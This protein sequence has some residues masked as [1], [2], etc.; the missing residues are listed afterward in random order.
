MGLGDIKGERVF[1]V[2]AQIVPHMAAIAKDKDVRAAYEID[3]KAG[4]DPAEL[5]IDVI[6][7]LLPLAMTRHRDHFAA[8]FA[9]IDGTD[10]DG[11]EATADD[12]KVDDMASAR[13][14]T[15]RAKALLCDRLFLNFLR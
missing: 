2:Y 7:K 1:E 5:M 3:V 13:D 14:F 12:Y 8:I 10:E 11:R 9:A 6:G 15:V 4:D